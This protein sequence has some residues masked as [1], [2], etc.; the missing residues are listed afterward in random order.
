MAEGYAAAMGEAGAA[1][2]GGEESALQAA[3]IDLAALVDTYSAVLYRVAYSVLRQQSEAED[4][5]QDAFV[6]V[7]Q[8][9]KALPTVRDM[10]VWLIR[11][12]WNL[13]ID[14]RRRVRPE[15]MDAEFAAGLVG[16]EVGADRAME[17]AGRMQSVMRE[18]Q[19]LNREERQ[20]LLLS[21]VDELGTAE[22]ALV[23]ERSEAAVRGLLFRGRARL[24]ERLERKLR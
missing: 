1:A 9:S 8:H 7:L 20:A 16:R 22:I 13:A 3:T 24:R 19:R 4:V 21:A 5:V 11:I 23:M 12:V 18:V 6:R 10:R 2:E 14:R 15:Q 17:E